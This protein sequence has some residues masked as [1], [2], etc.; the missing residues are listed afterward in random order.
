MGPAE[1]M[2]PAMAVLRM[3]ARLTAGLEDAQHPA[4][5]IHPPCGLPGFAME[6]WSGP[7]PWRKRAI[8][9]QPA[10]VS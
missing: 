3:I 4:A 2:T 8:R 10:R 1:K 6:A 7:S 5:A 9:L